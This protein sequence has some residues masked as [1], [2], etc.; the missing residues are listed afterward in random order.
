M[1]NRKGN[2]YKT[3][4]RRYSQGHHQNQAAIVELNKELLTK[5]KNKHSVHYIKWRVI[6]QNMCII[7]EEIQ[8]EN[9]KSSKIIQKKNGRK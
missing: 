1:I 4:Q 8:I 3:V 2:I 9:R 6:Q 5:R 7:V